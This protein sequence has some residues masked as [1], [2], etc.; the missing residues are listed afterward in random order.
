MPER[1]K[2]IPLT[3]AQ[4]VEEQRKGALVLDTRPA[5]EFAAAHIQGS[6]QIGLVGPV[7]ELGGN[8]AETRRETRDHRR[9]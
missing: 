8:A 2:L 4:T 3:A 7:F 1:G 9:E 6:I 5:Q